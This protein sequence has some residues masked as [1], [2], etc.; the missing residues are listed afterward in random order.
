M[1]QGLTEMIFIL[2]RSG[3]MAG[4]EQDTIGGYNSLLEKQR[5]EDGEAIITTVLFDD[6]YELVHDRLPLTFVAGLTSNEYFVRG[7]TALLDAIGRSIQHIIQMRRRT[8]PDQQPERTIF[9]ITTDGAENASWEFSAD[10]IKTMIEYQQKNY[11]WEFLFLGANIDAVAAASHVGIASD[12]AVQY[13]ADADGTALN[14]VVI[15]EAISQIRQSKRLDA[16][17]KERVEE[18]HRT[19]TKRS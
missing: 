13:H 14:Y 19:R 7:T 16:D 9:V 4:L 8:A 1:K 17:W 3:S 12:R 15:G 10:R 11:H 5:A 2:D 6:K 18:D